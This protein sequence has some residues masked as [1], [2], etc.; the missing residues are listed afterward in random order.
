[1]STGITEIILP[2]WIWIIDTEITIEIEIED[3]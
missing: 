1:M 2:E 3:E